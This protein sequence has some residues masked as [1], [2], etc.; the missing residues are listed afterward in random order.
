MSELK[1]YHHIY[2]S[3]SGYKT[4]Y[5]SQELQQ[6]TV[7]ALEAFSDTLYPK[8]RQQTLRSLFHPSPDHICISRIFRSSADHAGR[9]RSC[10]HNILFLKPELFEARY[11]NPFSFPESLFIKTAPDANQALSLHRKLPSVFETGEPSPADLNTEEGILSAPL[12]QAIFSAVS[13]N[14]DMAVVALSFDCYAFLA[15]AGN[16]LP[17]AVR[18]STSV[19]AGTIYRS[20]HTDGATIYWL[21]P[22]YDTDTLRNEGVITYD[23]TSGRTANLPAPNRYFSFIAQNLE[24][25]DAEKP[26]PAPEEQ[27]YSGSTTL[28]LSPGLLDAPPDTKAQLSGAEKVR[29]LLALVHRYPIQKIATNDM[30]HN[31]IKAF[32]KTCHCFMEDGSIDAL[33]DMNAVCTNLVSFHQAGYSEI[34]LDALHQAFADLEEK[35]ELS[36]SADILR[37]LEASLE[38]SQVQPVQLEAAINRLA[39]WITRTYAKA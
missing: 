20:T 38:D 29:R 19:V 31:L 1:L 18:L 33:S 32:E 15:K 36:S 30:Y 2:T 12:A 13:S 8:V 28:D 34:V 10:V 21:T 24:E 4:I 9:R 11:A 27:P 22:G 37:Q 6:K 5:A 17:P 16:L 7:Q 25:T 35:G 3:I 23:T 14:H 26:P 39:G